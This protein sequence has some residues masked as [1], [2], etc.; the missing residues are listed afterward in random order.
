MKPFS[1]SYDPAD[2][3]FL[4]CPRDVQTISVTE[5]EM[6]LR[7]GERHYSEILSHEEAPSEDYVAAYQSALVGN[8]PR[9]ARD[10]KALAATLALRPQSPAGLA[11]VSLARAGTPIGILLLRELKRLGVPAA[12]Y[13]IS[14]VRDRGIDTAALNHIRDRHAA[15]D[16]VFVDGWTGKG[17]ISTELH[18]S[19]DLPR[20]GIMPFLVVVA[21]PAGQA[22]LAATGEDYLIPSG[23]LNGIISGLISRSI[24]LPELGPENYHGCR[25][26]HELKTYDLSRDFVDRVD[27]I[28][29]N[30]PIISAASWTDEQR[31]VRK[32][33]CS[34]L[35]E[36]LT[37]CYAIADRNR[38]KPGIAEATRAVLRRRPRVILVSGY[39]DVH[40][41]HLLLL[42]RERLTPVEECASLEGYRAVALL[43]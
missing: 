14:I 42:C 21:D 32:A 30:L 16:I 6:L 10:I 20:L 29:H 11:I 19:P 33:A 27:A 39:Y 15:I 1:G 28:M 4:L 26:L 18:R 7:K 38:I 23:I 25:V 22:N 37:T 17:A 36:R 41:Q 34:R 3:S 5:K 2:V 13:S 8:G 9:L 31:N 40:L 35:I 43:E 24:I 12:H